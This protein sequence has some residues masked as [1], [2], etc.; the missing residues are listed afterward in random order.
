MAYGTQKYFRP[1]KFLVELARRQTRDISFEQ[2]SEFFSD[3]T[4]VVC[5][6]RFH[7][8]KITIVAREIHFCI[9]IF[10]RYPIS[11]NANSFLFRNSTIRI[12]KLQQH[13]NIFQIH[14]PKNRPKSNPQKRSKN[15]PPGGVKKG[16]KTGVSNQPLN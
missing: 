7:N 5:N 12:R 9:E 14:H 4:R 15:T 8:S 1:N 11:S 13:F 3:P 10:A 6:H 2:L 16:P